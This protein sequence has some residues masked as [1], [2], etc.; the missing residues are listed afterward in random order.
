[1]LP[2]YSL[3]YEHRT[4]STLPSTRRF[5]S[6]GEVSAASTSP[7]DRV[8]RLVVNLIGQLGGLSNA[9]ACC[10]ALN[11]TWR[12]DS[13]AC[14]RVF[15][16]VIYGTARNE[17]ETEKSRLGWMKPVM[18]NLFKTHSWIFYYDFNLH[19]LIICPFQFFIFVFNLVHLNV[20]A[21]GF[22]FVNQ[23]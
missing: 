7:L 16:F 13:R 14:G 18:L 3:Y 11:R 20:V 15:W 4:S 9:L 10:V 5:L 1:M 21:P 12:Y 17:N 8:A 19:F 6:A 23:F 22:F 2:V